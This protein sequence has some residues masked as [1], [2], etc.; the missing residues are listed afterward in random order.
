MV[1]A[2]TAFRPPRRT[3]DAG[4]ETVAGVLAAGGRYR[5]TRSR[6]RMPRTPKELAAWLARPP[7]GWR[8]E[9][10]AVLEADA[11]G[12]VERVRVGSRLLEVGELA[13]CW[14]D[15]RW[16]DTVVRWTGDGNRPL[17]APVLVPVV[18]S[19]VV[20]GRPQATGYAPGPA[21][22]VESGTSLRLL[23]DD[24]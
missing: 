14:H 9:Q 4:W 23:A 22:P 17:P 18:L 3:D 16:V 12:V 21:I 13:R 11:A 15:G 24:D 5:S 19:E 20:R 10:V 8:P 2:G 6:Q 1:W 7:T